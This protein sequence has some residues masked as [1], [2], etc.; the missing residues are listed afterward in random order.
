M[1]LRHIN[2]TYWTFTIIAV[3]T[4]GVLGFTFGY[5]YYRANHTATELSTNNTNESTTAILDQEILDSLAPTTGQEAVTGPSE[6]H[7]YTGYIRNL[8]PTS[9]AVEQA[10]NATDLADGLDFELT[11]QTLYAHLSTSLDSNGLPNSTEVSLAQTD[12][13]LGDI[14]TVYCNENIRTSD[15]RIA[16]KVQRIKAE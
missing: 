16:T 3:L 12:L 13:S 2:S 14:V 15:V 1:L 7:V 5:T 4:A 6:L 8:T 11:D 9:I 10:D